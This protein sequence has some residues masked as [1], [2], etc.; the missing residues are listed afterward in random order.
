MHR[1]AL[2]LALS[3]ISSAIVQAAV[4]RE[5]LNISPRRVVGPQPP[6]SPAAL[7][8]CRV[9]ELSQAMS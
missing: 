4:G 1:R 6:A 8:R 2:L 9:P 5:P 3:L 7:G